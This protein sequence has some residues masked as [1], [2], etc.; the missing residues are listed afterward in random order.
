M[1]KSLIVLWLL[2]TTTIVFA[3]EDY[4][5]KDFTTRSIVQNEDNSFMDT[6]KRRYNYAFVTVEDTGSTN[7]DSLVFEEYS[8]QFDTFF[9]IS[10]VNL[11]TGSTVTVTSSA[12]AVTRYRLNT[13][14]PDIIRVRIINAIVV[15][16]RRVRYYITGLNTY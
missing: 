13:V 11:A 2:L 10:A 8:S 15:A 5:E 16:G 7:K 12:D 6:L 1:L 3:Q 9:V 14:A 4:A